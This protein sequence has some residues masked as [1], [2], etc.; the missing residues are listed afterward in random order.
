MYIRNLAL[1]GLIFLYLEEE[2]KGIARE[3]N[4]S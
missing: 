3:Q 4:R 2:L 1:L